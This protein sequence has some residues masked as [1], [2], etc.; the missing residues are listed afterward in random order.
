MCSL[1]FLNCV[2]LVVAQDTCE[3]FTDWRAQHCRMCKAATGV[4]CTD[5]FAFVC[6]KS[7]GDSG[8]VNFKCVVQIILVED[9]LW[10]KTAVVVSIFCWTETHSCPTC[11]LLRTQLQGTVLHVKML[12]DSLEGYN[13]RPW[14]ELHLWFILLRNA[15]AVA[16]AVDSK[17]CDRC[18]SSRVCYM[19]MT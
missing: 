6:S 14:C 5:S 17:F 19:T 13:L 1:W 15:N 11:C 9:A 18:W 7:A 4:I 10:H 16:N 2:S 8:P 3:L 12:R